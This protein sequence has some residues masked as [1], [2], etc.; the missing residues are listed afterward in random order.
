MLDRASF[1][2]RIDCWR[3]CP[4]ASGRHAALRDC[5]PR[6]RGLPAM[7]LLRSPVVSITNFSWKAEDAISAVSVL[8]DRRAASCRRGQSPLAETGVDEASLGLSDIRSAGGGPEGGRTVPAVSMV[9][10]SPALRRRPQSSPMPAATIGSP[11]VTTTCCKPKPATSLQRASIVRCS[12]VG[13]QEVNGV[14]HHRHRRLQPLVRKK[15]LG[16]PASRPSPCRD[17]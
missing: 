2:S 8:S 15:T 14:S 11:P 9:T 10:C 12:P 7:Q 6:C 1:R 3:R 16:V 13:S 17:S 5:R 4:V